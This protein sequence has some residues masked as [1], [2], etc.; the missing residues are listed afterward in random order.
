MGYKKK[1]IPKQTKEL[2]R[3]SRWFWVSFVVVATTFFLGTLLLPLASQ[4]ELFISPD[5]TAN[6]YF[7]KQFAL[8]GSLRVE[9]NLSA[10][11]DDSLYPRSIVAKDGAL[12]PQSFVG[13]PV[14]YGVLINLFGGWI[15]FVLTPL[16]VIL[17]ALA[18][19]RLLRAWFSETV[20]N[21]SSLLFLLHPAVWYYSA[22]GLMHNVLFVC[23]LIFG[24][25]FFVCRPIA[26]HLQR[27]EKRLGK[28]RPFQLHFDRVLAGVL[29]GLSLF[30]RASEVYWIGALLIGL[31]FFL[32]KHDWKEIVRLG[33]GICIGILP[34]FWLNMITYGN[35]LVTGYTVTSV[36]E[37]IKEDVSSTEFVFPFGVDF[38]A[39]SA[40]V[41]D[42]GI[43]LF[44]WLS[45]LVLVG[46]PLVVRNRRWYAG[47]FVVVAVW[48]GI[49]YGS[50]TFFDN[51]DPSQITIANS[52]IRY[53]LPVF[54]LAIPFVAE[55]IIWI[56]GR[57]R[58]SFAQ[59]LLF[60]SLLVLVAGFNVRLVF[61]EG[62]DALIRMSR[63]LTEFRFIKEDV[64]K[65]TPSDSVIIVDRADKLFFPDRHIRY[66]LRLEQTYEL[67]PRLANAIPLYYFGI[68]F[69]EKDINYL[70]QTKLPPLGLQIEFVKTYGM[71]SLYRIV[72]VV[73]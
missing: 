31:V 66:P 5:E 13:L 42:Y 2:L 55:G 28:M 60:G 49:W 11:F 25:Y 63:Q 18:L 21:L 33:L 41:V 44:W 56:V 36:V 59:K 45:S 46:F 32:I 9:D 40:H 22:R 51:P 73:D 30:V 6:A 34:F 35:P 71:E 3:G 26:F 69:P 20:A 57:A 1:T 38:R 24:V 47:I 29:I 48:L 58:G 50:W 19:R 15:L 27:C 39:A 64:L 4:G 67:M 23:L 37:T 10:Q 53:W 61:F 70:N 17:A 54:I 62:Q 8:S 52:Y 7:A 12:L 16:L 65:Q 68:T 43:V 72:E 14:L